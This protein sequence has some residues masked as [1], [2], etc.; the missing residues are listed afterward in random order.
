MSN[1]L[2]KEKEFWK[3]SDDL[4]LKSQEKGKLRGE[5]REEK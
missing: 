2:T 5:R 1:K 3:C 4:V